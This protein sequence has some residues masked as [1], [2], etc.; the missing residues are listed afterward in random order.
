MVV[1]FGFCFH[2]LFDL[3]CYALLSFKLLLLRTVAII[4]SFLDLFLLMF[5]ALEDYLYIG[6]HPF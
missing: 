2:K 4:Q 3:L 1:I 6:Y 5:L